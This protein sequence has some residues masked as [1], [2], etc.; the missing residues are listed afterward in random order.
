MKSR[1]PFLT[2]C[3]LTFAPPV[4]AADWPQW[5]GPDRTNVSKET[6]LLKTWPKEGP[7]LL[8]T[9]DKAGIGYSGPA[10]VGDKLYTMGS[11]DGKEMIF[12]LDVKTGNELWATEIGKEFRYQQWGDGPRSTPTVDGDFVYAI[13]GQGDVICVDA[14][15]KGEKVWSKNMQADLGGKQMSSWGY[16]ESPLIDGDKLLC[17]PGGA[18]GTMVALNKK[19]GEVIW[20]AK[21]WDDPAG[22]ASI[23]PIEFNKV[24]QYVNMTGEHVVGVSEDGKLLWKYEKKSGTAA[25]PTPIYHDGQVYATSGY[26]AG[27]D[28]IKL[29]PEAGGGTFKAEKVYA[30]KN[31]VNHHGGVVLVDGHL[32]GFSEGKGWVCQDLKTGNNVWEEKGKLGKGSLTCA[33]GL[34]YCYAEKDG[35]LVLAEASPKGWQEH[36]RFTIPRESKIRAKNGKIWT[37]PV[38]ANGKLYLRDQDLIFCFDIK[39]NGK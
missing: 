36:G 31:V 7:K 15:K 29:S 22:Y 18:K 27:C 24:R 33:E 9:F 20:R 38:I 4:L 12:A 5:Q 30:N 1:L 13:G 3:C 26:G 8:W 39:A 25:I 32:Y 2:V 28:L 37:H 34:I 17:T 11:R 19:N 6:G 21:D 14:S 23:I 16:T 10:V 35:T